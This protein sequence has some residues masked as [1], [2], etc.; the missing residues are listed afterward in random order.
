MIQAIPFAGLRSCTRLG[1]FKGYRPGSYRQTQG[2]ALGFGAHGL[3]AA[4]WNFNRRLFAFQVGKVIGF[5]LEAGR[6]AP[7][8]GVGLSPAAKGCYGWR[9]RD[10]APCGHVPATED[11]TALVECRQVVAWKVSVGQ[12]QRDQGA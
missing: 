9:G 8:A 12:S 5:C 1:G 2:D 10:C 6:V 3:L 7:C 4:P 11:L